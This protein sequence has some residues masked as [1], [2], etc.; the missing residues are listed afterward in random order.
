MSRKICPGAAIRNRGDRYD[1]EDYVEFDRYLLV[2]FTGSIVF[3]TN[4][5]GKF[6]CVDDTYGARTIVV[7]GESRLFRRLCE[8]RVCE[9]PSAK[10]PNRNELVRY[11]L[12]LTTP[13]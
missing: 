6:S 5:H 11:Q 1:N 3:N 2:S 13:V 7:G 12:E 8:T 10:Y 9:V 4:A